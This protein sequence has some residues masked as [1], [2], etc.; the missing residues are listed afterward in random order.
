[1]Q[2]TVVDALRRAP[3]V[4]K[5]LI[6][7]FDAMH[8][9]ALDDAR[10]EAVKAADKKI[11]KGLANVAAIDEDRILRLIRGVI[12][13]TLRTNAFAPSGQ[14]ALAS[15]FGPRARPAGAGAVARDLG[16]SPRLEGIHLAAARS[17]AA[18]CDGP[19]GATI[20][21]PRCLA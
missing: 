6:A 10:E 3:E 11:D 14:E 21:A 17:P 5:G 15:R 4:T 18:A 12:A 9:P 13:A 16:H 2:I 7:L 19:T 8:D 20:S 1:M